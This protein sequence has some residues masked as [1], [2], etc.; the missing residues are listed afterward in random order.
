M[1]SVKKLSYSYPNK[2]LYKDISFTIEDNKHCAFIGSNGTG[3]STL[4]DMIMHKEDYIYDGK[5]EIKDNVKVGYVSQFADVDPDCETTVFDYLSEEFVSMNGDMNIVCD[6]MAGAENIELLMEEYQDILDNMTRAD[7]DNY[8]VNIRKK[9]KVA[10]LESKEKLE[11]NKL[12]G[13]EFKLIQV[14]KEMLV[15]PD[16][17]IM[18]EPDVYLDFENLNALKNL[19]NSYKG[20]LIVI[21][22]N[23]Y[24]LRNCFD[25]IIHLENMEVQEYDGRYMDYNLELLKTKIEI[26]KLAAADTEEIERNKKIVEKLRK[27]ATMFSNAALGRS[28]HARVSIVERLEARRIKAPFLEIKEPKITFK[29][30]KEVSNIS[31]NVNVQ[32][33]ETTDIQSNKP[34]IKVENYNLAFED[35]LLENVSFEIGE[36]DKVAIVGAN[37]T[38]KSTLLRHISNNNMSSI[39]ISED[40]KVSFLSQIPADMLNVENTVVEE[41][42]ELG[43]ENVN[44]VKEYLDKFCINEDMLYNRIKNL[45]GGEKNILQLAKICKTGADLLLLDEPNSHL[46]LYAQKALEKAIADFDGAVLMVSHD[47]YTVANCM[48]YVLFVEN[49]TLRK[50]SIRKFR[51]MI[52]ANHFDKDYLE[53]EQK[54]KETEEKV[55]RALIANDFEKA[56]KLC[57]ELEQ[58]VKKL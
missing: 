55:R 54:R 17:M 43:F 30:T 33:S 56:E 41:F 53:N 35:K 48:D 36:H 6:R 12:S 25:K 58:I 24:L 4:V 31:D 46:D 28:L 20:T 23:R 22:H 49:N 8:E 21:T 18:D 52:Y 26:S 39:D 9:L 14:M 10:G 51:K 11:I 3:K 15:V 37:G 40:V 29:T 7:Y 27:D 50:M 45:S 2:D 34:I 13:G 57:D 47:F 5:I 16:I 1:L 19:I 44:A 38:G 42:E 32:D